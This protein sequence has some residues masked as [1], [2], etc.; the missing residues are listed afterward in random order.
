MSKVIDSALGHGK[1]KYTLF[2]GTPA[3]FYKV[4][5]CIVILFGTHGLQIDILRIM[6]ARIITL[7]WMWMWFN[8][9]SSIQPI[10]RDTEV[11]EEE[12]SGSL[13]YSETQ[14][15]EQGSQRL[16]DP[17]IDLTEHHSSRVFPA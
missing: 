6:S 13:Q 14:A 4:E 11:L 9:R 16:E 12:S 3:T 17:V 10:D 7:D 8:Q 5:T 15:E 2:R 1:S